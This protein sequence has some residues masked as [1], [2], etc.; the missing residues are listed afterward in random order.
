MRSRQLSSVS[1]FADLP[2]S[3]R[4]RVAHCSEV[5]AFRAGA[6]I[7]EEG[8]FSYRFFAITEGMVSVWHDRVQVATLNAGDFFGEL[9]VMPQGSLKWGR[10]RATVVA[11]THVKTVGMPA[12]TCGDVD[13][14]P[15]IA[16]A[17]QAAAAERASQFE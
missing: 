11:V 4:E 13:D 10:R 7:I 3:E 9:G 1:L 12:A 17:I 8:R 15:E 16:G 2:H 14:S 5:V 6:T